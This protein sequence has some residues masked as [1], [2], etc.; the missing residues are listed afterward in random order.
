MSIL[1]RDQIL[2]ADDMTTQTVAVPEWGGDVLVGTLTGR[3]RDKF[4]TEFTT[5][6]KGQRGMENIRAKLCALSLRGDDGETIFT[7]KDV[8]ELGKKSAA[9]LDRVFTAALS[10]NGFTQSDVDEL[11]GN[12]EGTPEEGST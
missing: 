6:S 9:A 10:L 1:T 11:A 7:L 4:E 2:E 12:S 5:A 3:Q 8:G